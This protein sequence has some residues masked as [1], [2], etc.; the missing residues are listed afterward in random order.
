MICYVCA[1][2]RTKSVTLVG[3]PRVYKRA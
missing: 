3:I 2:G 1:G